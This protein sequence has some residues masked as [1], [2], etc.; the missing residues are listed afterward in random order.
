MLVFLQRQLIVLDKLD[1]CASLSNLD[2]LTGS[3]NFEFVKGDIRSLDLLN[4][5]LLHNHV[6]TVMHF[7]AQSHVDN[8]FGNSFEFT[9]N[10][11]E[12]THAI[13]EAS[14]Q[15]STVRRF[16]HVS[17]DEVY[18]E[19][20]FDQEISNTEH[21]SVLAPTN[22]YSATK[23]GAE[24]L[25]M[26]Y[27]RSYNLPFIITRGN[28]VYGPCQYP[29][30]AVAKFIVLA[31]RE[32]K[33]AIHGSGLATR[34]YMHVDDAAFAFDIILHKGRT[35][36]VY[37]IGA[38]EE[39]SVISVAHDVCRLIG[40]DPSK[41]ISHVRDRAFNDRRYYIDCSKLYALGWSQQTSW[42]DG[43]KQTITWYKETDLASW[44]KNYES[45][46]KPHAGDEDDPN[47]VTVTGL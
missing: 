40:R 8:S 24:M 36:E 7:A 27:G 44:W 22:P 33:M 12:G 47:T 6:D 11:T 13:L 46:L 29:E 5:V 3:P 21:S 30:K 23:A 18:G 32:S 20:S 25:V 41:T 2:G 1:Y 39:R 42:E 9:K 31:M 38:H 17:T 10:N 26:A 35:F 28:N 4:H 14:K 37:N 34:S 45:A 43:L 19:T 16:L 15:A